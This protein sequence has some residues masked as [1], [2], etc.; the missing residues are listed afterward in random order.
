MLQ[1]KIRPKIKKLILECKKSVSKL[2]KTIQNYKKTQLKYKFAEKIYIHQ[3]GFIILT[4][5]F[6]RS[7]IQNL[8]S[9]FDNSNE[10]NISSI[11][12]NL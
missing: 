4:Q 7:L 10:P 8:K 12:A 6:S 9:D 2:L 5:V 3:I 11:N 1:N